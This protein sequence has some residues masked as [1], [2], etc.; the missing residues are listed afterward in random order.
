MRFKTKKIE[1]TTTT[2]RKQNLG[3]EMWQNLKAKKGQTPP[4]GG[5]GLKCALG[6]LELVPKR[7]N[8]GF[9]AKAGMSCVIHQ[10]HS[11]PGIAGKKIPGEVRAAHLGPHPRVGFDPLK[12]W[13]W[14]KSCPS[15]DAEPPELLEVKTW[16][17]P[18]FVSGIP[19]QF[20]EG[21]G[22]T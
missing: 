14:G 4:W 21:R 22:G 1:T 19:T 5:P 18:E 16:I 10:P 20:W 3:K 17:Y 11:V 6:H 9:P 15:V 2:E 13:I 7:R 8:L 12:T